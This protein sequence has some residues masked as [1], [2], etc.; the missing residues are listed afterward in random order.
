[1]TQSIKSLNTCLLILREAHN[2]EGI[3]GFCKNLSVLLS[4]DG[5]IAI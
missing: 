3:K 4:R 2:P 1:M 5:H